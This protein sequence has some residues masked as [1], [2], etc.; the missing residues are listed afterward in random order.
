MK[1]LQYDDVSVEGGASLMPTNKLIIIPVKL[2]PLPT[3]N[4][5]PHSF[6]QSAGTNCVIKIAKAEILFL[7]GVDGHIIQTVIKEL[8]R[9]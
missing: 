6:Q 5:S 4:F 3:E 7:N 1:H 8:S 2:G 9:K